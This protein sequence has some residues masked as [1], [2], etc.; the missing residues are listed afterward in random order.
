MSKEEKNQ[1][2]DIWEAVKKKLEKQE[3]VTIE[4][5]SGSKVVVNKAGYTTEPTGC[6][7]VKITFCVWFEENDRFKAVVP[8]KEIMRIIE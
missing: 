7:P 1:E 3:T 4:T 8:K 2:I 5:V 6:G